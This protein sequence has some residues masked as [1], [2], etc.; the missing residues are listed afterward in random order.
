MLRPL[1][2]KGAIVTGGGAGIGAGYEKVSQGG[3][4]REKA[5]TEIRSSDGGGGR[6]AVAV[7]IEVG[8]SRR[9]GAD[10]DHG[11]IDLGRQACHLG[12]LRDLKIYTVKV[13][14]ISPKTR[15]SLASTLVLNRISWEQSM[16]FQP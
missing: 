9:S 3:S 10:G 2:G 4:K 5:A 15:E 1:A 13:L 6:D 14:L 7:Q 8:R 16:Q 12:I 11:N